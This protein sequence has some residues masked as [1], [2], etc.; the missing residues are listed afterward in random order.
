M[1]RAQ[2][3]SKNQRRAS[4]GNA[5]RL[6]LRDARRNLHIDLP[7]ATVLVERDSPLGA[8]K[9]LF[10]RDVQMTSVR[11]G[12]RGVAATDACAAEQTGEEIAKTVEIRKSLAA[13]VAKALRPVGRRPKLLS[14]AKIPAQLVVGSA[15]VAIAQDF[16]GLLYLFEFLFRVLFLADIRVEFAGQLAVRPLHFIRVG[17]STKPK[18]FVVVPILHA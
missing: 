16:V 17:A 11:I 1:V 6:P 12:L 18:N 8:A 5:Q 3:N 9:C 15:F 2:S 14:I 10:N 7:L 13:R 4:S